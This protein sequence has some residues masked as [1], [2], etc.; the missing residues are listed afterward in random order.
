MKV[1]KHSNTG[2]RYLLYEYHNY[3]EARPVGHT[4]MPLTFASPEEA[5]QL[6]LQ[7]SV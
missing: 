2:K 5:S 7:I 1:W 4:G 6:L 3:V